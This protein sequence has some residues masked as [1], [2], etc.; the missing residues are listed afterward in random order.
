ML[1]MEYIV[2]INYALKIIDILRYIFL[3]FQNGW[4]HNVTFRKIGREEATSVSS[5]EYSFRL[6]YL[7]TK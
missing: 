3:T 2:I 4:C 7:G 6:E 1:L 5:N